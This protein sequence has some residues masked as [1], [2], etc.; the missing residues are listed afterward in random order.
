MDQTSTVVPCTGPIYQNTEFTRSATIATCLICNRNTCMTGP[1]QCCIDRQVDLT[2][3]TLATARNIRRATSITVLFSYTTN[4]RIHN[5]N[6]VSLPYNTK[7]YSV[8]PHTLLSCVASF[9]PNLGV[10]ISLTA[11]AQSS[12]SIAIPTSLVG[13]PPVPNLCNPK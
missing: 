7:Q 5:F 12:L 2:T 9:S 13:A 3:M 10:M 6:A 1:T 4:S 8:F 11:P